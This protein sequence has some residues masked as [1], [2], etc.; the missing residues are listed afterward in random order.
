LT[1]GLREV[2]PYLPVRV[3]TLN[4]L[5]RAF[6]GTDE[7]VMSYIQMRRLERARLELIAPK[8][9]L[10]ISELAARWHFSDSS[11][12]TRS[13]RKRYG[14]APTEYVRLSSTPSEA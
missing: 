7:S 1:Y 9:P 13:F 11:H 14:V 6:A 3:R 4:A 5:Y 2:L 10:S 8:N 12:F